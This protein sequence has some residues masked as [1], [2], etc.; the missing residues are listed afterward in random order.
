MLIGIAGAIHAG[1][2]TVAD[3]FVRE[4]GYVTLRF[5]DLIAEELL[6]FYRPTLEVHLRDHISEKVLAQRGLEA[7]LRERLWTHR[8]PLIRALLQ[9]HGTMRRAQHLDYWVRQM[10]GRLADLP[11]DQGVAI[12]GVRYPNE[13]RLVRTLGG[14]ILR[15]VR[16]GTEDNAHPVEHGLDGWEDWDA[17]LPNTGS[18]A[19][20]EARVAAWW[21]TVR[22]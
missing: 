22:G 9:D 4:H 3:W 2:D 15:V 11:S 10:A 17:V 1:K 16:P 18:L 5:S 8:T 19:D 6:R 13:I 7:V 12:A 20:L 14:V 21:T